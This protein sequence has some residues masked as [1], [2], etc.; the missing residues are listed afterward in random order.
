MAKFYNPR[1]Y[2]T[3][4]FGEGR[5]VPKTKEEIHAEYVNGYGKK[6]NKPRNEHFAKDWD[7]D[8]WD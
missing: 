1:D 6:K 3:V 4:G 5:H 2:H 7:K 8:L